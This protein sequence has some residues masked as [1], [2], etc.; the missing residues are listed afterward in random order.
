MNYFIIFI[1]IKK[2]IS[3]CILKKVGIFNNDAIDKSAAL[4]YIE[5]VSNDPKWTDAAKNAV[6]TCM[7]YVKK[8][9]EDHKGEPLKADFNGNT[10]SPMS[11]QFIVCFNKELFMVWLN[12]KLIYYKYKLTICVNIIL[13]L[14]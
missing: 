10:C 12:V 4:K 8:E 7:N 9:E 1:F 3:Q 6:D 14:S 5:T 2:C 11:G 13:E